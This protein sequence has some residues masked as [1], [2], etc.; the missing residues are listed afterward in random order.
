MPKIVSENGTIRA[1]LISPGHGSSGYYS[2]ELLEGCASKFDSAQV[3]WDHPTTTE[4]SVRPERSLR[5]LAGKI[6]P[7]TAKW[8]SAGK[9]GAGI[10]ADVQVFKPFQEAV[11]ELGPHIGMSIRASGRGKSGK[12]QG[13]ETTIVESID[14]VQSVDFV[15]L[16]GRGGKVLQM[17]EA[18]RAANTKAAK[19]ANPTEEAAMDAAQL[20]ALQENIKA[21]NATNAKLLERALRGDARE[22]A[23]RLLR[24]VTLPDLGKERVIEASLREIPKT[25]A[26]ELDLAKFGEVVTAEAKR[27]GAYVAQLTNAGQVRGMGASVVTPTPEQAAQHKEAAVKTRKEAINIF[28]ALGLPKQAATAAASQYGEGEAA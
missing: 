28:E 19:P 15:T 5:D 4:E 18:A 9:N 16:A 17:F 25:E 13:K 20:T 1:R 6:M 3:Y 7:G 24:T 21:A 14:S 12:I 23:T 10:Y 27:E 2:P 22:E 26:G 8:E 11:D